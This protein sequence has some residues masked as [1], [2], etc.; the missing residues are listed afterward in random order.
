MILS[1]FGAITH[2]TLQKRLKTSFCGKNIKACN[3][4]RKTAKNHL[5]TITHVCKT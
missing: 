1:L 3:Q 4:A 2:I 5:Y